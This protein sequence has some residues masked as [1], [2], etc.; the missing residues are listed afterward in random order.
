MVSEHRKN[1]AILIIGAGT[2]GLATAHRLAS[3]GYTNITVLEKDG[4]IPS[5]FS[6]GFDLNK[7]IRAEYADSFYT[8]LTLVS[9]RF[10]LNNSS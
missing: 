8:P 5:R 10:G 3:A 6:A 7:I 2:F 9:V 4:Q 1:E